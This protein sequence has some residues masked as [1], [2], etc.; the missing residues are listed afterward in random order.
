MVTHSTIKRFS[1]DATA[2]SKKSI[3]EELGLPKPPT[4][5]LLP[6]TRYM[7]M[8]HKEY[9][10]LSWTERIRVLSDNWN[11][12]SPEERA[13]RLKDYYEE[14]KEFQLKYKAYLSQLTPEQV[15]S[16][17]EAVDRRKKVK[18]STKGKREKKKELEKLGRPKHPNNCFV[19]FLSS[20]KSSDPSVSQEHNKE[21]LAYAS[22]KWKALPETE[23]KRYKE[24]GERRMRQYEEEIALWEQRM[25]RIGRPE[26]VRKCSVLHTDASASSSFKAQTPE[27]KAASGAPSSTPTQSLVEESTDVQTHNA[28]LESKRKSVVAVHPVEQ[29]SLKYAMKATMADENLAVGISSVP[30]DRD[31]EIFAHCHGIPNDVYSGDYFYGDS[32]NE[33]LSYVED[34]ILNEMESLRLNP[35]Q[36]SKEYGEHHH[37]LPSLHSQ[38]V[39]MG[40]DRNKLRPV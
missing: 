23:R 36:L 20:L 2:H 4:K 26:L 28:S 31:D 24:E 6:F 9:P 37:P 13:Q 7:S 25:V 34:E 10:H 21:F 5:P 32:E 1:R 38:T 18:E 30:S 29:E 33:S 11:K 22:A 12:Q 40:V 15:R 27:T 39:F 14:K 17:E 8:G 16:L 35:Q 3:A 19:L